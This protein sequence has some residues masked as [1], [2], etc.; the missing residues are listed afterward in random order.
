MLLRPITYKYT[1]AT[2]AAS[3]SLTLAGGSVSVHYI[4]VTDSPLH[5][6][7]VD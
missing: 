4:D 1:H 6:P 5:R 2:Y 3:L 7:F